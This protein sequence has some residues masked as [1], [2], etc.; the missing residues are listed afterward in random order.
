MSLQLLKSYQDGHQL[1]TV[2][3]HGDLIVIPTRKSGCWHHDTIYH[4]VTLS[5]H[6]A[7]HCLPYAVVGVRKM[8]NTVHTVGL[9]LTSLAFW[10]SVLPLHHVCYHM[11]PLYPYLH[12]YVAP[13]LW[14]VQTTINADRQPREHQISILQVVGL[15][16]LQTEILI[17]RKWSTCSGDSATAP[18]HSKRKYLQKYNCRCIKVHQSHALDRKQLPLTVN[19]TT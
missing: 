5:L 6:W 10:A 13:C 12:V 1:V 8:G 14:S 9:K 7:N 17:S 3:T 16:R 4:S 18:S 19:M 11:S 2:C 15:T